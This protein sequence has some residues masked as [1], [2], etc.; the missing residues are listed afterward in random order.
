MVQSAGS[1]GTVALASAVAADVAT[2][3]ERGTYIAITSLTGILAPSLGPILGGV[4]SQDA[5]WH[6]KSASMSL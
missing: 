2:S 6:C 1:S 4:L 3:A 5:G